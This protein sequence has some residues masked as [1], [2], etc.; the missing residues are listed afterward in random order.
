MRFIV[1]DTA[2]YE[3]YMRNHKK[4]DEPTGP[5]STTGGK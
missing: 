2:E 4:D 3:L 1:K 5:A